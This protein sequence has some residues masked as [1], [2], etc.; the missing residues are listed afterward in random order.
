MQG[1][2]ERLKENLRAYGRLAV[3]FS[4]G[5]DSAFL[6]WAAAD[7][8][9]R[10]QV[11]ALTAVSDF[12]PYRERERARAV[13]AQNGIR[14]I[15]VPVQVLE[16]EGV[17]D[18]PVNRCYLCKRALFTRLIETAGENGIQT[19]AE[20]SNLDDEGDYRPGL[21]AVR[22]LGVKSPLREAMLSK[23]EIRS[24]SRKAGLTT[25]DLPSFACLASRFA[26]GE[27]ITVEKLA[28]VERAEQLLFDQGFRQL[29]VRVHGEL[30]GLVARIELPAE[31]LGRLLEPKLRDLVCRRLNEL[32][33]AYVSL[34]LA[35]FRSGN[36]NKGIDKA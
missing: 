29:R 9:G 35:G 28:M 19:L 22:E 14:Q 2:Q 27:K 23:E 33:F 18:N 12:F 31:D 34:D 16:V 13:C 36:M 8:L 10:D 15:E 24:L 25:W 20:A 11:L 5:V 32:G 7:A 21:V 6:L 17:A 4:G 3:A 26:Y 1:K 30:P